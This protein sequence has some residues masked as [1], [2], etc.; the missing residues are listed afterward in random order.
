MLTAVDSVAGEGCKA[1]Q[2]PKG[3]LDSDSYG[4]G[5]VSTP[6]AESTP[7][8]SSLRMMSPATGA[9]REVSAD[10]AWDDACDVAS[11]NASTQ[12]EAQDSSHSEAADQEMRRYRID[13]Y[14]DHRDADLKEQLGRWLSPEELKSW[15]G[16]GLKS[17]MFEVEGHSW[18]WVR[19][20]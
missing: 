13:L 1:I 10:I 3:S 4:C 7:A 8:H 15:F 12:L 16:V 2:F 14:F 20:S 5:I 19:S 17:M 18:H 9:L 11:M 6:S